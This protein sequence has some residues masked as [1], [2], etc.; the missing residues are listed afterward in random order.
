MLLSTEE[1]LSKWCHCSLN[2]LSFTARITHLL[3]AII[4]SQQ[5]HLSIPLCILN[6]KMYNTY[7]LVLFNFLPFCLVSHLY[8]LHKFLYFS[9]QPPLQAKQER[10][11]IAKALLDSQENQTCLCFP[12]LST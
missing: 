6:Y 8:I 3:C 10:V 2:L 12:L 7:I 4:I 11:H 9:F 5:Y 1:E